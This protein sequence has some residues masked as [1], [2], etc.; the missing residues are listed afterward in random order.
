MRVKK[1]NLSVA[2][3]FDSTE[4]CIKALHDTKLFVFFPTNERTGL[5][6]IVHAPYKTT[7]SRESIPFSDAQN[8]IITYELSDLIT[9][10]LI[11]IKEQG[12]LNVDFLTMLPI[13]ES[14]EHPIYSS[15]FQKV[16]D[17]F[18]SDHLLPTSC[19]SFTNA[20]NTLLAREKELA[21]LLGKTTLPN[22]LI[23]QIGLTST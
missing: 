20:K 7:P 9:N 16:R 4:K 11:K 22:Y 12:Y 21:N 1:I 2:Y 6:F 10:T 8:K 17:V 19:G 5:N 14:E 3:L 15:C 23:K 18:L 13:N